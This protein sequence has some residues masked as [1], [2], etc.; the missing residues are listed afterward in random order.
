MKT[1]QSGLLSL[2]LVC[3]L[4][5]SNTLSANNIVERQYQELKTE[6]SKLVQNPQLYK[7]G[8]SCNEEISVKF[9]IDEA[10]E[11]TLIAVKSNCKYLKKFVHEKLHSQVVDLKNYSPNTVYRV[12]IKFELK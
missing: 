9:K 11:I 10:G 6:I 1:I 5:L 3:C 4:F 12:K 2:V 7:N 8:I